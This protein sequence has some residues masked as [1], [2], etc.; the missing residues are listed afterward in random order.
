MGKLLK[1]NCV[2]STQLIGS[3]LAVVGDNF[4]EAQAKQETPSVVGK[5][6]TVTSRWIIL[7]TIQLCGTVKIVIADTVGNM[8]IIIS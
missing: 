4:A 1:L 7:L 2:H 6:H 8:Y 5:Y 3:I